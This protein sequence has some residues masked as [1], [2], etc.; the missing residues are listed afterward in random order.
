MSIGVGAGDL[1]RAAEIAKSIYD[2][3]KSAP[4]DFLELTAL[5]NHVS[6]AINACMPNNPNLILKYQDPA[7]VI[8]LA[9]ACENT[10][11]KLRDLLSRYQDLDT[12][13]NVGRRILFMTK[14]DERNSIRDSL[15]EQISTI[16]L[17]QTGR[18]VRL[19]SLAIRLSLQLYEDVKPEEA[20]SLFEA[21]GF[22]NDR[23]LTEEML[24]EVVG[25][26]AKGKQDLVPLV[27]KIKDGII[28]AVEQD[29]IPPMA[30]SEEMHITNGPAPIKKGKYSP[31][32]IPWFQ[33]IGYI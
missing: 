24:S 7:A 9:S 2:D 23:S 33:T 13:R 5:C 11:G 10:L 26:H 28:R 6:I 17:F 31:L 19:E 15:R 18:I 3:F 27:D 22:Q 30:E 29:A 21:S 16:T 8:F 20:K 25:D 1:L 4:G 12:I 14:K 32:D